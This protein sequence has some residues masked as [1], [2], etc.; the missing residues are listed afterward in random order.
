MCVTI[1]GGL[2]LVNG[3]IDHLHT[4]LGTTSNYNATVNLHKST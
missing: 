2:D 1:D 4:R 3:F